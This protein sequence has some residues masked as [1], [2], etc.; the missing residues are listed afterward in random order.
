MSGATGFSQNTGR[1]AS[2]ARDQAPRARRSR[3]RRRPRPDPD[4]EEIVHRVHRPSR[5]LTGERARPARVDVG[6]DHRLD[7]GQVAQ[8]LGV[9]GADP[10]G[11]DEPDAHVLRGSDVCLLSCERGYAVSRVWCGLS[12]DMSRL[13][14][15][16]LTVILKLVIN[17]TIAAGHSAAVE[18]S[19]SASDQQSSDRPVQP[20]ARC[21]SRSPSSS[22]PPIV[23]GALPAG[24]PPRQR[25]RSSPT[26]SGSPGPPC[27]RPS[28]TWSTRA[29]SCASAASAPRSCTP[30]SRRSRA[31]Q[32]V[33]RPGRRA[34]ARRA[35]RC[36]PRDRAGPTTRSPCD[37]D[38]PPGADVVALQRLR[39]ADDEPLALHAQLPARRRRAS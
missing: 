11:T 4:G 28:S 5:L 3:R 38:V 10:P 9:Q 12:T 33:R 35:R 16:I 1:P 39:Y 7:L 18:G 14:N 19:R 25:D 6:D 8:G 20:G 36:C 27:A 30:R 31:D 29:C 37:L 17:A 13:C 22:R 32:P 34:G 2:A 26:G 24:R 23:A 15:D 21:T